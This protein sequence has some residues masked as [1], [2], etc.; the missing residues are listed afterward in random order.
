MVTSS[1]RRLKRH[2]HGAPGPHLPQAHLRRSAPAPG[3]R[4]PSRADRGRTGILNERNASGAPDLVI[5]I[6]SPGTR[7]VDETL[8]LQ[9]YE[10]AG[11]SEYWII[12]PSSETARI[13]LF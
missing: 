4:P 13:R 1:S 6:L 5:E 9:L 3:R 10:R 8:K 2:R 12:D 7:R 11:V